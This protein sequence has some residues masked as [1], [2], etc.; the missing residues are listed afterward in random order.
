MP[1]SQN[2]SPFCS[3]QESEPFN[4]K[5]LTAEM[6]VTPDADLLFNLSRCQQ[7]SVLLNLLLKG[8]SEE[9]VE[10]LNQECL[11]HWGKVAREA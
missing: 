5:N 10:L 4:L 2:P 7:L 11:A 1:T 3:K 6:L 8:S 9:T